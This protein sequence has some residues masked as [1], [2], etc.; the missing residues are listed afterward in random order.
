MEPVPATQP[1]LQ[2]LCPFCST[3]LDA[4]AFFCPVCGKNVREKPLSTGIGVQIGLY[5]VSILLPPLSL[6][7]TIKY[8]KSKDP[9]AKQIGMISLG[10]TIATLVA[11]FWLSLTFVKNITQGVNQQLNQYQDIGL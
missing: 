9:K 6:I 4:A 8:L 10:L 2:I 7:W 3:P 11:V 5:A 1:T